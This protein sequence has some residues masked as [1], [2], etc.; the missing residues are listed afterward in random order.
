M[1][2]VTDF[3][4]AGQEV[5]LSLTC[6]LS[7]LFCVF[8]SPYPILLLLVGYRRLH[9]H[10]EEAWTGDKI[11][12]MPLEEVKEWLRELRDHIQASGFWVSVSKTVWPNT[13]RV[14]KLH[15]SSS[16][17]SK[18]LVSEFLDGRVSCMYS[19]CSDECETSHFQENVSCSL[20]CWLNPAK[21]PFCL[22]VIPAV[23]FKTQQ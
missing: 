22:N 11:L 9:W 14:S 6:L 21:L 3:P 16:A 13:G 23:V 10:M 19:S 18:S 12:E 2:T 5:F 7:H 17:F 8:C 15:F 20:P 1:V 4:Q